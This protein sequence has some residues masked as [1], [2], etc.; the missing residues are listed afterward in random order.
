[1]RQSTKKTPNTILAQAVDQNVSQRR[2]RLTV[3]RT[4][5]GNTVRKM[6]RQARVGGEYKKVLVPRIGR[7]GSQRD[8]GSDDVTSTEKLTCPPK[9][10][11]HLS[12]GIS[13]EGS[14]QLRRR[15]DRPRR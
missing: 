3:S 1:M 5:R 6:E 9:S 15:W 10:L 7:G 8:V 4:Q 11:H 14:V 12:A 2:A 13:T